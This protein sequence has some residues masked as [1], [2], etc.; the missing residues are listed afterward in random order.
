MA[1]GLHFE[2]IPAY[3]SSTEH[4]IFP[5]LSGQ[6]SNLSLRNPSEMLTTFISH[7]FPCVGSQ[8][9][10]S[11]IRQDKTRFSSYAGRV[12]HRPLERRGM[13]FVKQ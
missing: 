7:V 11:W 4:T 10:G 1:Q 8:E 12:K 5:L 2:M 6:A 13:F 3:H 9:K